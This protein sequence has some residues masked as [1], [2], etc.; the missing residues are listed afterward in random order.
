MRFV[1]PFSGEEPGAD[2]QPRR[3]GDG[4]DRYF[5]PAS[6]TL[7]RRHRLRVGRAETALLGAVLGFVALA[8]VAGLYSTSV[9]LLDSWRHV[10]PPFACLSCET[11]RLRHE[12]PGMC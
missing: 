11:K 12:T 5:F 6:F 10:A 7:A 3:G 2:L 4:H 1:F 9:N 8:S